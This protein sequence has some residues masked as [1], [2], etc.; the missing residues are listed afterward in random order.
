MPSFEFE[1]APLLS[2][3]K[4]DRDRVLLRG[5]AAR[6]S[7]LLPPSSA[8][9]RLL[10]FFGFVTTAGSPGEGLGDDAPETGLFAE[11]VLAG[12]FIGGLTGAEGGE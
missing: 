7:L 8:T 12:P 5:T 9:I 1:L 2:S 10:R 11:V 4:G 6:D 3:F